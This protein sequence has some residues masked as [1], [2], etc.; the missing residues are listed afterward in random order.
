MAVSISIKLENYCPIL[1]ANI[2][3]LTLI[4]ER[5]LFLISYLSFFF[6]LRF[7][8][9][10]LR[11]VFVAAQA[12]S[13]CREWGPLS[14]FS[15]PASHG[16][17]FRGWEAWPLGAW[18]S[19]VVVRGCRS[20]GLWSTASVVVVQGFS[21]SVVCG[22]FPNQ[23]LN[24]CPLHWQADSLPLSHQGS[25]FFGLKSRLCKQTE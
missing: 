10:W 19:V 21:C 13:S 12:F 3:F 9:S 17:G 23:G 22:I 11:W 5:D 20:C 2:L 1:F 7:I 25:P 14:A 24:P 6:F 16:S 8:C 18:A 15:A 4:Q